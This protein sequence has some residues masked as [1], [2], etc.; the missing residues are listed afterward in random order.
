MKTVMI[1]LESFKQNTEVHIFMKKRYCL[2]LLLTTVLSGCSGKNSQTPVSRT[3][4]AFDTV[5]TVTIYD[6]EK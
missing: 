5:V 3:G 1:V 2:I 6:A 4:F